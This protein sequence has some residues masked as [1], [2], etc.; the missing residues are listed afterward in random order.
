MYANVSVGIDVAKAHLDVHLLPDNKRLRV[1]NNP[2]G[3]RQLLDFISPAR[4]DR[5]VIEST[6]GYERAILFGLIDAGFPTALVNPTDVRAF[7]RGSRILAE[8]DPQDAKLLAHFGCCVRTRSMDQSCKMLHVLKQ[9]VAL[10]RQLV[11]QRTRLRNQLEHADVPMVAQSIQRSIRAVA[12]EL[13]NVEKLIQQQI[14]ADPALSQRQKI[15]QSAVGVGPTVSAV[16][17]SELPELG[18]LHRRKI[19]ALVGVAPY[20]E[21]SG[22]SD[23]KRS[24]KG[25]RPTVRAALY[26]ATLVAIRRDSVA[27]AHYQRLIAAGKPKKVAIV[28]CMNKRINYL[29]SLL[30]T[31]STPPPAEE[32]YEAGARGQSPQI[33]SINA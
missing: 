4:P 16:L 8:S 5:V 12:D 27:K 18:T 30:R 13:K 26:M 33:P 28:A 23:A 1:G 6:G 32:A 22:N 25:G 3:H 9:L 17:V 2:A 19:A 7:A 29:N 24:I 11:D 21:Q 15:L 10:R 20:I 31:P 14:D